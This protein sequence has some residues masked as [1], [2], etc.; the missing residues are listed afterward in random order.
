[1]VVG[2]VVGHDVVA[3]LAVQ[4]NAGQ[5]VVVALVANNPAV[6]HLSGNDDSVLLAGAIHLIIGNQQ[7]LGVI[8]RVNAIHNVVAVDVI[9]DRHVFRL[10][11]VKSVVQIVKGGV[12]Q[13]GVGCTSLQAGVVILGVLS[14]G[15][16]V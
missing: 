6:I 3:A 7:P 1:V 12:H 16:S 15:K 11:A 9:D 2:H 10:V 5:T 14:H 13:R 4:H 8:V